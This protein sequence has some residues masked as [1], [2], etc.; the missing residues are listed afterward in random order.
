VAD[1]PLD[2][3][4]D[5]PQQAAPE[6]SRGGSSNII[7]IDPG[8]GGEDS[9]IHPNETILEK[10]FTAQM[11]GLVRDRLRDTSFAGEMT[12]NRDI[13]LSQ[14]QR[15][16][17]ANM[18]RSRAFISI[19]SG[20]SADA[21]ASG[22][23]VYVHRYSSTR[24][25]KGELRPWIE[26]QRDHLVQSRKLAGLIQSQLNAVF[27]VDN[28]VREA[29]LA[30]LAPIMGPAVLVEVGFLTNQSDLNRLQDPGFQER[31]ADAIAAAL[32]RFLQ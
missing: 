16:S 3:D 13:N 18:N 5:V 32:L 15:S 8:H 28:S 21:E 17:I 23:V 19:H 11:A 10:D 20:A 12:R 1:G 25:E 22:P 9:G 26:G 27:G 7:T 31:V 29:P 14:D 2:P 6:F 30:I 4:E 24:P